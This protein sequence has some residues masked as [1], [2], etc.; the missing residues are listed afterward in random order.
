MAE[1]KGLEPSTFSVTVRRSNQL[2]YA[3][4]WS[5]LSGLNWRPIAYKAIALPTELRWRMAPPIRF[6]LITSMLTASCSTIELQRNI[7]WRHRDSNSGP[8]PCKGIALPTELCPHWWRCRILPPSPAIHWDWL[9]RQY[10]F[11]YYAQNKNKEQ[12]FIPSV[13]ASSYGTVAQASSTIRII[14]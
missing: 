1:T 3:S 2:S 12:T 10:F 7:W 9:L 8:I 5:H 4:E 14:L 13:C 11:V 6:E